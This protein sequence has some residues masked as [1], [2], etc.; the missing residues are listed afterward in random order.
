MEDTARRKRR[1]L[2]QNLAIVALSLSAVLLFAQSQIYNLISDQGGLTDQLS[3]ASAADTAQQTASLTAP[4]RVAVTGPYDRYG[5]FLTTDAEAFSDLGLLLKESLGSAGTLTPCREAEFVSALNASS[6]FYDFLSPLPLSILSE[7]VGGGGEGGFPDIQARQLV[8]SAQEGGVRLY[9]WDGRDSFLSCAV[10][11]ISPE[12]LT[13]IVN[14][15]TL[16]VVLFAFDEA[17]L[18]EAYAR[19]A[20]RSLLPAELPE[21]PALS[22]SNPLT[23]SD[24]LLTGLRFN[25]S[26]K[27]RY[28]DAN[29]T[30][31]IRETDRSLQI[32]SGGTVAYEGGAEPVVEIQAAGD[33]PTLLEAATGAWSLLRGLLGDLPGEA[34][35]YLESVSRSDEVTTL[36]FG[37]HVDGV[38]VRFSDGSSAAEV[39]LTGTV[40]TRLS[41]R[42]R[43]YTAS[44]ETSLLLP[45][46][47]ALA[48]AAADHEGAELFIGYADG[49][50]SVSAQWMAE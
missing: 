44:G 41:L 28:T 22:A 19:V 49:G 7:L 30:E 47:Q 2:I 10:L 26:T 24:Q 29:G 36:R 34:A 37:Y 9:V 8:L 45:L 32:G 6:V 50:A 4:V 1:D 12:D 17:E 33:V 39:T 16:P 13:E 35:L 3:G 5:T 31:I 27:N 43:Q 15:C 46:R 42:F 11:P 48:I 25:P 14:S 23:D 38:P 18:D 20:P 21:L 40:V